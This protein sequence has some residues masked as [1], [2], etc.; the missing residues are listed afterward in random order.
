MVG[1]LSRV[2]YA[3]SQEAIAWRSR[4]RI[5]APWPLV[6]ERTGC[7][8]GFL[9]FTARTVRWSRGRI[10]GVGHAGPHFPMRKIAVT[11]IYPDSAVRPENPAARDCNDSAGIVALVTRLKPLV[12]TLLVGE[13]VGG[14][15]LTISGHVL[16]Q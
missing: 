14:M 2:F 10:A 12:P 4:W 6:A 15:E 5:I 8:L 7:Y 9:P 16:G 3:A 11:K 13:L 1:E